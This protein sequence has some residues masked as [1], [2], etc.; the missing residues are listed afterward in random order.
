MYLVCCYGDSQLKIGRCT[1]NLVGV[2]IDV[3]VYTPT[4]G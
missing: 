2:Y 3:T 1:N 4:R